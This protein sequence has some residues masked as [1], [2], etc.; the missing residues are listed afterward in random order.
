MKN[1]NSS[2]DYKVA[3]NLSVSPVI[4]TG[5]PQ[6]VIKTHNRD[7]TVERKSGKRI[8]YLIVI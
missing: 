2:K 8:I 3:V 6:G 1:K 7:L 5:K 4:Y